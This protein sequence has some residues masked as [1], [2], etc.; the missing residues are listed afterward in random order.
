MVILLD[1]E[2]VKMG[3]KFLKRILMNVKNVKM[4]IILQVVLNA[5]H[6]AKIKFLVLISRHVFLVTQIN[7]QI[8]EIANVQHVMTLHI[9]YQIQQQS[10]AYLHVLKTH[11]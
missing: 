1:A 2:I 7:L 10:H 11:R 4:D 6:A 3:I 8:P 5:K 9:F